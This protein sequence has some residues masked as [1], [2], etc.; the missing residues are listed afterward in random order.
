MRFEILPLPVQIDADVFMQLSL[1]SSPGAVNILVST[2]PLCGSTSSAVVYPY[3]QAINHLFLETALSGR[4]PSPSFP[5]RII[6]VRASCMISPDWW[7]GIP[8][9]IFSSCQ[10]RAGTPFSKEMGDS[11]CPIW[12]PTRHGAITSR[13]PDPRNIGQVTYLLEIL[14]SRKSQYFLDSIYPT[15]QFLNAISTDPQIFAWWHAVDTA[16]LPW[17]RSG[18]RCRIPG[19][20]YRVT[21]TIS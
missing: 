17:S 5:V 20:F 15:P 16:G 14:H 2:A 9:V 7:P 3:L 6:A 11:R 18:H 10:F 13:A 12:S 21:R 1:S 8:F 19:E 4:S